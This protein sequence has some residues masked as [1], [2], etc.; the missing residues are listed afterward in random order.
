M[1]API[2]LLP[3]AVVCL[4]VA[5]FDFNSWPPQALFFPEAQSAESLAPPWDQLYDVECS[6]R[7]AGSAKP[8]VVKFAKIIPKPRAVKE[9]YEKCME[10]YG[11]EHLAEDVARSSNTQDVFEAERKGC[12]QKANFEARAPGDRS[13]AIEWRLSVQSNGYL[14]TYRLLSNGDSDPLYKS[15]GPRTSRVSEDKASAGGL[16]RKRGLPRYESR[17]DHV[18]T[19]PG[20][21]QRSQAIGGRGNGPQSRAC[22]RA[23]RRTSDGCELAQ[24]AVGRLWGRVFASAKGLVRPSFAALACWRI[25][26]EAPM[27]TFEALDLYAIDDLF[28]AEERM[29]RDSMRKFVDAEILPIIADCFATDRFPSELIPTLAQMGAFGSTIQGYGCAGLNPTAY[30]LIMQEIERGDSGLRSFVSV[31]GALCMHPIFAFG[32]EALKQ[33]YLPKMAKGEL[34]GCFGLTEARF[35]VEPVGNGHDGAQRR[36]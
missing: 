9:R 3:L 13:L 21:S 18:G 20:P 29:I 28:T 24:H 7:T 31:Q 35:W 25:A 4:T 23:K 30:G 11:R 8:I 6:E 1:R 16:L 34:I 17:R 10:N 14:E 26:K 15:P 2:F 33:A 12:A 22:S 36:R 32:D 5:L 27:S 19:K